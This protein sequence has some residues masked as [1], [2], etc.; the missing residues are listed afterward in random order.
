MCDKVP[1]KH[2]E[3]TA[4]VKLTGIHSAV[5]EVAYVHMPACLLETAVSFEP[6]SLVQPSVSML[7]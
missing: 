7:T 1:G 3:L 6:A 2:P 5:E 4:N